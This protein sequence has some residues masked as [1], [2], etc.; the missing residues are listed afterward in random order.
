MAAEPFWWRCG[1]KGRLGKIVA[2]PPGKKGGVMAFFCFRGPWDKLMV[3]V[4]PFLWP[5]LLKK[6][7][8]LWHFFVFVVP[9]KNWWWPRNLFCGPSPRKKRGNYG[10]FLFSWRLA[11]IG[12]GRGTFF[13]ARP[14]E[15]KGWV[16]SFFCFR[17]P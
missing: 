10:I 14:P 11:Q 9:G 17:G 6:K 8:E 16:V 2:R 15:K 13:V 1:K 7:G 4:E 3:A 12:G 5:V